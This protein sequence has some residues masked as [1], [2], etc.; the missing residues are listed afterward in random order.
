MP[1]FFIFLDDLYVEASVP[2]MQ[3]THRWHHVAGVY[4]GL[5]SRLYVDGALV[6]TVIRRGTRR[7]NQLPLMVGADVG[8][9]GQ[10]M[11]H[12]DGSIDAVRLSTVARYR[13]DGFDPVRRFDPDE[14][15]VLLLNLDD[16]VGRWV[17]DSSGRGTHPMVHGE[18][19]VVP[20][21]ASSR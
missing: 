12:F 11:A 2:P 1:T 3:R 17:Y 20:L 7:R 13:G 8:P 18:P 9:R 4:D 19:S 15:T 5:E 14:E 21:G 6:K 16:I 10:A